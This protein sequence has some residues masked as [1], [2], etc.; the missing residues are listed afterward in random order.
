M[1]KLNKMLAVVL[2]LVLCATMVAPA[3]AHTVTIEGVGSKEVDTVQAGVNE[4]A[5][6]DSKKGNIQMTEDANEKVVINSGD[7]TID[8][9]GYDIDAENK[10]VVITVTGGDLTIQDSTAE[11]DEEG[12]QTYAGDGQITG[13]AGGQGAGVIVKGGAS[14][15]LESGNIS[16]NNASANGGGVYIENGSFTMTGGKISNNQGGNVGGGV[17]VNTQAAIGQ[18][19]KATFEMTGGEISNNTAVSGG[20]IGAYTKDT[21]S[22]AGEDGYAAIDISG[23]EITGN[24]AT[25]G[26]GGGV[27]AQWNTVKISNAEISGNTAGN[28]GG[29]VWLS[30]STTT[31]TD[32]TITGNHVTGTTSNG[33][34]GVF[35]GGGTA[36]ITGTEISSNTSTTNG[37]G[38]SGDAN[39]TLTDVTI[40]NNEAT[41]IGGGM[42]IYNKANATVDGDSKIYN[43]TANRYSDDV[44]KAAGATIKLPS[45]V[46]MNVAG[47]DGKPITGWYW[48]NIY[49]WGNE[50]GNSPYTSQN[51]VATG[52]T[53]TGV[54]YLKAAHDKYFDVV[55]TDGVDGTVFADQKHEVENKHG[56]PVYA[57]ETPSRTGYTFVG[58]QL[59]D[60]TEIDLETGIVTGAIELVAQWEAVPVTVDPVDPADPGTEIDEPAVPLASGPVTR[61]EFVDYLWR[62]EGEPAPVED[63]G[64]FEDV[65][66]EHEFSPAMAWAKSVG[67]ISAYEDGT[68]EPDELVTVA[69]VREILDNFAR[70]FGTNA[71]A[72]ADLASLSG[73]DGEAVLNCD[74]VLAEFFGEE[75]ASAEEDE[76]A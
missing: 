50:D 42:Y 5:N 25:T 38:I 76:A 33:G 12:K 16:W 7:V 60:G 32:S 46:S 48:D 70:V 71:V 55:Y 18:G 53:Y 26:D 17:Y 69:A 63:S 68:F 35:A 72:A 34:G 21:M 49:G 52:G 39:M 3:F 54:L 23:G 31:V 11:Y 64:L 75:Y 20:G 19:G 74:E 15:T 37:G 14:A 51:N 43:N 66:E 58:W 9:N 36:N 6:S 44:F 10:G 73:D 57:G 56:I 59:A 67:I 28:I 27:A 13:G 61:A 8:L 30:N 29:G 40:M 41:G 45:A 2:S 47:K 4:I 1:K 65:T 24:T 62:H 22:N